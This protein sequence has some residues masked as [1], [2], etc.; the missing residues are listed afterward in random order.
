MA[1]EAVN[2]NLGHPQEV[3]ESERGDTNSMFYVDSSDPRGELID[4]SN[5]GPTDIAE[6]NRIMAAM[7]ALR[8]AEDQLSEASLSYMKLNRTDMRALHFLIVTEN[9]GQIATPSAIAEFLQISTAST[10]KLLD[11]LERGGHIVRSLHP[12]DRRALK[13]SVLPGTR[14]AAMR[15]VGKQH[16]KRFTA[17]IDLTSNERRV[18]A[19]FLER[20][21]NQL[22]VR[23]GEWAE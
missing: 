16:A 22:E 20:M 14:T 2:S 23:E 9:K 11:R 12:T 19:E 1:K 6:I 18:V 3:P 17:S 4:R 13:I 8:A 21:A 7:A 5:L 15:T 10:T